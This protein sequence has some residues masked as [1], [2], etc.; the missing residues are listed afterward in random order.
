MLVTTV[1]DFVVRRGDDDIAEEVSLS[2]GFI[3]SYEVFVGA[4]PP[5]NVWSQFLAISAHPST[6]SPLV[7]KSL[8][9]RDFN[10]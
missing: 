8:L 1:T 4:V 2:Y 7:A 6:H 10:Y 9:S 5:Q 3:R